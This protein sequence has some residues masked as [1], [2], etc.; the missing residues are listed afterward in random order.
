M[1]IVPLGGLSSQDGV[2]QQQEDAPLFIPQLNRLHGASIV[3]GKDASN[4]A[5]TA[6]PVQNRI[7]L[8]I[9]SMWEPFK[10]LKQTISV[11]LRAEQLRLRAQ[12]RVVA[13][14]ED[15]I[16]RSKTPSHRSDEAW[17]ASLWQNFFTTSVGAQIPLLAEIIAAALGLW[18]QEVSD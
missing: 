13:T 4:V 3:R 12:Q 2:S 7:T 8:Q 16:L 10:V 9:L 17:S 1:V 6:M 5:V 11:S 18:L 14:V 15:S